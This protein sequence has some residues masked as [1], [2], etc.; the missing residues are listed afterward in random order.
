MITK[1]NWKRISA[2]FLALAVTLTSCFSNLY[3]IEK[4]VYADSASSFQKKTYLNG[5]IDDIIKEANEL[6]GKG[7]YGFDL[8]GYRF[9]GDAA[10]LNKRFVSEVKAPVC[11]AGSINSFT[12]LD[13][14]NDANPWAFTIGSAFFE[15]KFGDDFKEQINILCKYTE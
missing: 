2:F 1:I 4:K 11:I 7:V 6:I 8:L 9:T 12:R 15:N 3:L 14:L 10:E 13:E 5:N